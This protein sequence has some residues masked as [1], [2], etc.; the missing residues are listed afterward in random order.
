MRPASTSAS[1]RRSS[2]AEGEGRLRRLVLR[3]G[4]TG[5]TETVDADA[6]F[7]LIGAQPHTDWL[8][9][10]ID[11]DE[12]GFVLTGGGEH[13]FETSLPGVFAI[14]DVRCELGEARRVGRRRGLG[15]DPAGAPLPRVRR[16]G[17][18]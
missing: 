6:V 17:G 4:A 12:R 11:R 15:S 13:M 2:G 1:R 16:P 14:G 18:R 9:D 5:G 7:V 3:D 8:P 10:D